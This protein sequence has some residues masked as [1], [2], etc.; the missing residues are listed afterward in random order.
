MSLFKTKFQEVTDYETKVDIKRAVKNTEAISITYYI[1]GDRNKYDLVVLKNDPAFLIKH[2]QIVDEEGFNKI[3]VE[4]VATYYAALHQWEINQKEYR[5]KAAYDKLC[6]IMLNKA[7]QITATVRF[8]R[9][10]KFCGF[11]RI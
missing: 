2:N 6:Q 3:D 1:K 8:C 4:E 9:F 7:H 11:V 10:V 5:I